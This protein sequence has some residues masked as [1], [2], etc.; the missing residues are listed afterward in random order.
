MNPD[1]NPLLDQS[2]LNA[3]N[4]S[5][6][7]GQHDP[8]ERE[9]QHAIGNGELFL[10]FQPIVRLSTARMVG[11]EALVRWRHPT[12]GVV[13]PND[14][15]PYAERNGLIGLIGEF[16]LEQTC[17]LLRECQH[18]DRGPL[19]L[20]L[21]VSAPQLMD[22]DFVRV[23]ARCLG[24]YQIEPACLRLEITETASFE[25]PATAVTQLRALKQLGVSIVL[26]DFGTGYSSLSRLM[27][28]EVDGLK[29]DGSF[30]RAVPH[31]EKAVK[32][33]ECIARLASVL[34][35]SLLVEGVESKAQAD[36]LRRL[37]DVQI[38][39]YFFSRPVSL[40]TLRAAIGSGSG[41]LPV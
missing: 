32:I 7:A 17:A 26:D 33:L 37:G 31:D 16:V 2:A 25:D 24:E 35:L 3:L 6:C 39:G 23:V 21:N 19:V 9:L 20:S 38:Q 1:R 27:R 34:D 12:R 29:V 5:A 15:I 13:M 8:L 40:T 18:P 14:F 28:L 36:W 41:A 10:E 30:A 11:A 22:G 4:T